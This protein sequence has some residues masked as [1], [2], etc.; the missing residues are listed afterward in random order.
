[1]SKKHRFLIRLLLDY[2]I[3]TIYSDTEE[4]SEGESRLRDILVPI[5]QA[6]PHPLLSVLALNL[7]NQLILIRTSY[8]QYN[9]A[10]E[11]AQRAEKIYQSSLSCPELYRL[12]ELIQIDATASNVNRRE[13]FEQTYTHTLFY[14]AQIHA[15]LQQKDQSAMYCRLTLERQ[16]TLFHQKSSHFD[17]LDWATNCATLSQYYMTN[18]DYATARHCMMCADL[19]LDHVYLH[20]SEQVEEK[21]AER[22]ASFK[23][24]WVKYAVN[25]LSKID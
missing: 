22:T 2:H 18:H 25:L 11:L 23:R 12:Q 20:P 17:G 19:M 4:R 5:E 7:V 10:I 13:E 6:L 21:L 3:A 24:C 8:E 15:K 16:L 9:D 1:M 14:L